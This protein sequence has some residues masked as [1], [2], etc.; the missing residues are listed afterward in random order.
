MPGR[1]N[2]TVNSEDSGKRLD[3]FVSESLNISRSRAQKLVESGNVSLDGVAPK[4]NY[5]IREGEVINIEPMSDD[6]GILVPQ[7][8]EIKI[9]YEDATLVVIDKPP[10]LVM[11]PAAGHPD[12]T[13]MNAL[14]HHCPNLA[15][16][17]GPLRPGIVHRLDKD[18]SGL[19]VVALEDEAYYS[20]QQQ[21]RERTI[22]R[23][24]LVLAYGRFRSSS[25]EIDKAIGRALSD[26]KKMSTRTRRGKEART[27]YRVIKEFNGVSLV[28][29]RL[30]TGRT[31]QIRVHFAFGGHPVLGDRTYGKKTSLLIGGRTVRIP[32]QML[33]AQTLGFKHPADGAHMLFDSPIP[34]DMNEILNLLRN[35][36]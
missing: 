25:G 13:L 36:S 27:C 9:V 12:G 21:F 35:V 23:R 3:Q 26:R 8:F 7:D 5:R 30:A 14:A 33:H 24:Y 2:L 1:E 11:Y 29:A 17:G 4:K 6:S 22:E 10:G 32:R 34:D 31:H 18:T 19:V 15:S 16:I 28:E 20:L